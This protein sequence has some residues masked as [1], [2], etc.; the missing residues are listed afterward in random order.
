VHQIKPVEPVQTLCQQ[1][2]CNYPHRLCLVAVDCTAPQ[3]VNSSTHGF[4][5][6]MASDYPP[7]PPPP[8][9]IHTHTHIIHH[10]S[11]SLQPLHVAR[12]SHDRCRGCRSPKVLAIM[13]IIISSSYGPPELTWSSQLDYSPRNNM[14]CVETCLCACLT[15]V[16]LRTMSGGTVQQQ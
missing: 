5:A 2:P 14:L 9:Y 7:V 11:P 4:G 16:W 8:T 3:L 6:Q 10:P 12:N 13:T 1:R 15:R